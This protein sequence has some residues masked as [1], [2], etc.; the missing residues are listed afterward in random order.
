MTTEE[1][2]T[3]ASARTLTGVVVSNRMDKTIT[4]R[5]ERR[6]LHPL[7]G[8]YVRRSSKILAHDEANECK[9]GDLVSIE[10]CRP[11]SRNKSWRLARIVERAAQ[12]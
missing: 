10:S 3:K 11:L 8:K 12:V 5:V 6:V 2:G 1:T 4:V 7:Y 9:E